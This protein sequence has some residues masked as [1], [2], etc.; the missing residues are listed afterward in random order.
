MPESR[1]RERSGLQG[2]RLDQGCWE[3][4]SPLELYSG[5]PSWRTSQRPGHIP[6]GVF[7]GPCRDGQTRPPWSALHTRPRPASSLE[8]VEPALPRAHPED[9][10]PTVCRALGASLLSG[11]VMLQPQSCEDSLRVLCALPGRGLARTRWWP[12]RW[13][14]GKQDKLRRA[15]R[16]LGVCSKQC[17]QVRLSRSGE[18]LLASRALSSA[19]SAQFQLSLE[20]LA[21]Q[22]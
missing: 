17:S 8:V 13:T 10:P 3:A 16:S 12:R 22:S 4:S 1:G 9:Q 6:S 5:T 19:S 7:L 18:H 14:P 15:R 21:T 11:A 20:V 2:Q